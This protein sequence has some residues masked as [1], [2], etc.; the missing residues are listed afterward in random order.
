MMNS[1]SQSFVSVI[2]IANEFTL[3]KLDRL[4]DIQKELSSKYTD[5]E[6][7]VIAMRNV[8]G[9]ITHCEDQIRQIPCIRIL[10]LSSN[11]TTSVAMSCG[12]EN[13]IGDFMVFFDLTTD[14]VELIEKAVVS[15]KSGTDVI[16][17]TSKV[18]QSFVYS[19]FRPL[20]KYLLKLCDYHLPNNS[21][22][23]RCLSRRAA[24]AVM[25]TGK[26]HHQFLM[27]IQKTGYE[28]KELN[29]EV[30]ESKEKT[31]REGFYELLRLMVFNSSRPLRLMSILAFLG[32]FTALFFAIFALI[33]NIVKND[34]VPGWTSTL[35]I[36]SLFSVIQF[37]ILAFISEYLS[38]LLEEQSNS[39]SYA[40]VFEKN[41]KV[42]VDLDRLNV[43]DE[44]DSNDEN[45]V[46]TGRNN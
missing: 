9:A 10:Q 18:K 4:A 31:F 43:L 3:N 8:Q 30:I 42:M 37:I 11:V 13:A 29:Y 17:G 25:S 1:K 21:T 24:N 35:V 15:C 36:I 14:P 40:V 38:R 22:S 7:L 28:F 33:I 23:F 44:A 2:T 32:S 20:A 27:R 16:V 5:Y 12:L 46:Q 34:V 26:F 45:K 19:L 41:S 39:Q 6:I